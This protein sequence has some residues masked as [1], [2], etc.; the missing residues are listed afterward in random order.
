MRFPLYAYELRQLEGVDAASFVALWKSE[1]AKDKQYVYYQGNIVTGA[2]SSWFQV[3]PGFD[4]YA[5]DGKYLYVDGKAMQPMSAID[6]DSFEF[7]VASD[8]ALDKNRVF[9]E[10]RVVSNADPDD[11]QIMSGVLSDYA[12]DVQNQY[13]YYRGILLGKYQALTPVWTEMFMTSKNIFGSYWKV[14]RIMWSGSVRLSK[15]LSTGEVQLLQEL[16]VMSIENGKMQ[17]PDLLYNVEEVLSIEKYKQQ[18]FDRT[19]IIEDSYFLYY[20]VD[21]NQMDFCSEFEFGL[22]GVP[23][24]PKPAFVL[25]LDRRAKRQSVQSRASYQDQIIRILNK[26]DWLSPQDLTILTTAWYVLQK[27]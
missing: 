14:W 8:Y 20:I 7:V 17:Y 12:I 21:W 15:S 11:F 5:I 18:Y 10:W 22:M 1:Y 13:L 6:I 3:L 16:S 24:L 2:I 19:H 23:V 4:R 27:N 9:Y 25:M 26:P